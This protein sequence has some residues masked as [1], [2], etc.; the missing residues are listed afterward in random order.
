MNPNFKKHFFCAF[1]G[2]DNET[3]DI[4]RVLWAAGTIV[5]FVL[6]IH[7]TYKGQPFDPTAWGSGFAAVL[8]GGGAALGFKSKTEPDKKEE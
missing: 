8:A 7:S 1:T 3:L 4:G 2:K 6:S 5:F